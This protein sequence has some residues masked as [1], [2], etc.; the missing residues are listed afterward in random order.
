MITR[1]LL[2]VSLLWLASGNH[3]VAAESEP[4]S[5]PGLRE[6]RLISEVEGIRPGEAFTLGLLFRHEA[7]YHTYWKSPGIVGVSAMIEWKDLPPGFTTGAIQWPGPQTTRMAQV[8]AWGYKADTCLLIPFQA[9]AD[10]AGRTEITLKARVGWMCC[11]T[12]CHPGWHD[13]EL[14]IPV[15]Q[16]RS[17]PVAI[18]E[19]WRGVF[20]ESRARMP[21]AAPEGWRFTAKEIDKATIQLVAHA[22]EDQAAVDFSKVQFFCDDNQVDS[23][24][25]Q[26][27]AELS[28]LP[29][30][31]FTFSR[32]E[33]APENPP[34]LSGVLYHPDG[35]PGTKSRWM[36]ASAPWPGYQVRH[37]EGKDP[38]KDK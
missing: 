38:K 26:K 11:A 31:I 8:T 2:S 18:G 37:A 17:G 19:K 15:S 6:L 36:I 35:W 12:S 21:V 32:P 5:Y 28:G 10:L 34:A 29:G 25:P 20:D 14:T 27:V 3:G 7:G 33:F 4:A 23:D 24:E 1:T 30:A 22:P 16:D 13:F 9:P